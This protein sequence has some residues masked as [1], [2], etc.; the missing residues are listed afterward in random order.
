M[1]NYVQQKHGYHLRILCFIRYNSYY[2][3]SPIHRPFSLQ[4]READQAFQ[5]GDGPRCTAFEGLEEETCCARLQ[6]EPRQ[7]R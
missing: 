4:I 7:P 6:Y 5:D 3:M 2:H 1:F